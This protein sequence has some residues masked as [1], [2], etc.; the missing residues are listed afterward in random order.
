MVPV[1]SDTD[2]TDAPESSDMS[3]EQIGPI[4]KRLDIR[5][6]DVVSHDIVE[7]TVRATW[8]QFATSTV[9]TFVPMLVE[10]DAFD[11]LRRRAF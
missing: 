6:G 7:Q 2:T 10:K 9:R 11:T 4:V 8:R 5:F 3:D 1:G